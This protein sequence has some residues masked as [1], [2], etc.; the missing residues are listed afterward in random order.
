MTICGR[1]LFFCLI[2][3]SFFSVAYSQA[4][5]KLILTS[6]LENGIPVDNKSNF[7][8]MDKAYCWVELGGVKPENKI[9][10]QWFGNGKLEQT[11]PVKITR[12]GSN[13]TYTYKTLYS[14]GNWTV[15]VVGNSRI[16]KEVDFKVG[17]ENATSTNTSSN[18]STSA[19]TIKSSGGT[20][21]PPRK[22]TVASG[23]QSEIQ[24]PSTILAP[25]DYSSSRKYPVIIF[26][27]FTGGESSRLFDMFA[28]GN[29]RN[30]MSKVFP[31]RNERREKSFFVM[32][33]PEPASTKDHS[34]QGFEAA[35]FRYENRIITD[36][37]ELKKTHNIDTSKIIL[38]GFSMGGD[39]GWAIT[40]RYP[41][42]FK[43][44]IISG[45]RTSWAEK[46]RMSVIKQLGLKF[47]FVMGDQESADR[48]NGLKTTLQNL[49]KTQIP[50]IFKRAP[51]S[52]VPPTFEQFVEG[53]RYIL[54]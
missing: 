43:G 4:V 31:D 23:F 13:T 10:I 27:P 51:G 52:H 6:R 46:D 2:I 19:S 50:Y 12:T 24:T 28:E 33:T 11:Y 34:W 42:K 7:N 21:S 41:D 53:L 35:T 40:Q 8:L 1:I 36:L 39:L 18:V 37:E 5:E 16:L 29:S 17:G 44:A 22:I 38:V 15:K 26:L 32:L 48:L 30:F 49:D 45:S 20:I 3:V 25:P 14:E 47:Y 54:Y 9:E